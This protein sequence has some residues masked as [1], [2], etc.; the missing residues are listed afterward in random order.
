MIRARQAAWLL[1]GIA[2]L[3]AAAFAASAR[4]SGRVT[5]PDHRPLVSAAVA[6]TP[7]D[8]GTG[9][10][11][12]SATIGPDGTFSFSDVPPGNYE[13]R[14]RGQTEN[15]GPTLFGTFALTLEARDIAN[16][17]V[18]LREGGTLEGAV[19]LHRAR[20][21]RPPPLSSLVVR[22]PLTDGTGF[23]DA[24]TGRVTSAGG[25]AI[26]GLMAGTHHVL[27]EG[28]PDTWMVEGVYLR[29]RDMTD[30]PFDVD[31]RQRFD[32]VR[33]T[34]TDAVTRLS[35]H[36]DERSGAAADV[37]VAVFAPSPELWIRGG[38]RVR[39]M[40]TDA[41]GNATIVG[42][43]F[44]P[45]LAAASRS[46]GERSAPLAPTLEPLRG[47]AT[48]FTLTASG[49]D[50]RVTLRLDEGPAARR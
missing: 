5:T 47:G 40:R 24:L 44:G 3:A 8:V 16:V 42:L 48:A 23:G 11:P 12:E 14:A 31:E 27:V 43:P 41:S 25:F 19:A 6:M 35:V 38:R 9:V 18:A 29:G 46:I 20:G 21:V 32:D 45:Y 1:T 28:L 22:A 2:P 7:R 33:V 17:V 13:I 26:R 10:R 39:F 50:A 4:V 37:G 49:A 30:A 15:D 36:V 34:I